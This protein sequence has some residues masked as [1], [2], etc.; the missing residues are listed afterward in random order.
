MIFC[1][2]LNAVRVV[3]TLIGGG[4]TQTLIAIFRVSH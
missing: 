1:Q 3:S 4:G 2:S